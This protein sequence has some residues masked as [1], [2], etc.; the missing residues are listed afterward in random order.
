[1]ESRTYSRKFLRI[2]PDTVLYG[3][4]AIACIGSRRVCSGAARVR[5]LDISPGG[6]RFVSSL[7]LPTDSTVIIVI[8]LLIDGSQY[9]MRGYIVHGISSEVNEYVYGFRFLEPDVRLRESL[10]KVFNKAIIRQN[11]HII[12]LRLN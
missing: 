10:K 4:I 3:M 2:R 8:T 11:R 1:M 5:I 6:L 7:R 9:C 12:I